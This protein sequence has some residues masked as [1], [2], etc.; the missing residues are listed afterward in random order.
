MR[1]N[2]VGEA[3]RPPLDYISRDAQQEG[4]PR[5]T[6]PL[7]T[8]T[9]GAA[10]PVEPSSALRLQVPWLVIGGL[11]RGAV[12]EQACGARAARGGQGRGK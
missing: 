11:S 1:K 9:A 3:G 12:Q 6:R 5:P 4:E 8:G 7:P 10:H 2:E